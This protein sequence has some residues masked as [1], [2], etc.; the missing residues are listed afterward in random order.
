MTQQSS[1]SKRKMLRAGAVMFGLLAAAL[2][3]GQI[4]KARIYQDDYP[5][6]METDLYCSFF[7]LEEALPDIRIIGAERGEEKSLFS[8]ADIMTIDGGQASG[9]VVG[10][11]FQVLEAGPEIQGL[12]PLMYRRGRARVILVDEKTSLVRAEKTCFPM[13]VGG[14]IVPFV[15][16][17]TVIGRNLGFD[18]HADDAAGASGRIVFTIDDLNIIR[19]GSWAL[20]DVGRDAGVEPGIQMTV[21]RETGAGK[22]REAVGNV[23][24]IDAGARSATI[25][26]L[27]SRDAVHMGDLVQAKS[28]PL[29]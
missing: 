19:D 1:Y 2:A 11:V 21:F 28:S 12:G 6:I 23:V 20:I 26:V 25:K 8:D 15:E 14:Y 29:S 5:L 27:S 7:V 24:V 10:Q 4:Q 18:A 16:R 3:F 13:S 22:P 9:V 17:E